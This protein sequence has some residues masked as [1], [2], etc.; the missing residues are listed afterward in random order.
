MGVGGES[1]A[2]SESSVSN[3]IKGQVRPPADVVLA[4]AY[5]YDISLDAALFATG[6]HSSGR[7]GGDPGLVEI[8]ERLSELIRR[9]D[10]GFAQTGRNDLLRWLAFQRLGGSEWFL[11][12]SDSR[13]ST[14]E[15]LDRFQA[16]LDQLIRDVEGEPSADSTDDS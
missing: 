6:A 3:W 9:V 2:Y 16:K 4:S 14:H 10:A 7:I 13:A 12:G 11:F 8:N 1:G 5:L 15:Y